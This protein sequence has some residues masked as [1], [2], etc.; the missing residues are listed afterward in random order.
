ME[1]YFKNRYQVTEINGEVS[2]LIKILAGVP[3]GSILGPLLFLIYINDL[4]KA[5]AFCSCLFADDTSLHMSDK[6]LKNLEIR[7]GAE[8]K[9]V[10]RWFQANIYLFYFIYD[11]KSLRLKNA[12]FNATRLYSTR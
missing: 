3:Q 6:N 7:A 1:N 8:L 4:P 12:C 5:S 9:L 11:R 2:N 10:E